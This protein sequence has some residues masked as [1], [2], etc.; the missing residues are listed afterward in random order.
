MRILSAHANLYRNRTT[1]FI[2]RAQGGRFVGKFS[3]FGQTDNFARIL[4]P[5]E[6]G[7]PHFFGH[8]AFFDRFLPIVKK[9]T[10]KQ[11]WKFNFFQFLYP[12]AIEY[13]TLWSSAS[14][15]MQLFKISFPYGDF[16][17]GICLFNRSTQINF[18]NSS[19]LQ[20]FVH[21]IFALNSRWVRIKWGGPISQNKRAPSAL[22]SSKRSRWPPFIFAFLIQV[23]H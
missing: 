6:V 23:T 22:I 11:C 13:R 16:K 14:L 15:G 12:R 21:D 4:R 20:G 9:W 3:T 19:L 17:R 10:K 18:G 7:D 2:E 1:S 8:I 5:L